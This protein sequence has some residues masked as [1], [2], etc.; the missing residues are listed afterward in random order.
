MASHEAD[1]RALHVRREPA[2]AHQID[3]QPRRVEAG[4][5]GD[6]QMRDA[7]QR[8]GLASSA[9]TAREREHRRF[10]LEKAHPLARGG[11][12]AGAIK[13]GAARLAERLREHLYAAARSRAAA[14]IRRSFSTVSG[15]PAQ[16]T[17][18]STNSACRSCGGTA[19]AM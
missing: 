18:D 12:L 16:R 7:P 14:A 11:E 6:D 1:D 4:A 10:P 15:G 17:S 2:R 5:G 3:I 9:R 8:T 19:Q 13:R